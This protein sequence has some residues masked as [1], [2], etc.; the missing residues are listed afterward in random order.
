MYPAGVETSPTASK[1]YLILNNYPNPF[2]PS[3]VISYTLPYETDVQISVFSA[4]GQKVADLLNAHQRAG[5]YKINFTLEN[6]SSG[7]YFIRLKTLNEQKIIKSVA[8]K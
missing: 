1:T 6:R 7:I 2:N 4:I 8:I 3:T 5:T